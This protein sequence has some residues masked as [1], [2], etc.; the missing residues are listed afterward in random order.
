MGTGRRTFSECE[1]RIRRQILAALERRAHSGDEL[2][3]GVALE[4][5]APW[6]IGRTSEVECAGDIER[7]QPEGRMGTGVETVVR[8]RH[9][10]ARMRLEG[11]AIESHAALIHEPRPHRARMFDRQQLTTP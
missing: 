10:S 8:R 7:G 6:E 2:I 11:D 3:A 5:V 9:R 4:D 1:T